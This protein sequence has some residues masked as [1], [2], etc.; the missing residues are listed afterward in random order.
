MNPRYAMASLSVAVILGG[1]VADVGPEKPIRMP[2][3]GPIEPKAPVPAVTAA[4]A[5]VQATA[6]AREENAAEL[7]RLLALLPWSERRDVARGVVETIG[8][9]DVAKAGWVVRAM[10]PGP[11]LRA[12]AEEVARLRVA[13]DPAAA[14]VWAL[15]EDTPAVEF[16]VRLAVAD[17]WVARDATGALRGITAQP[18]SPGR[19]EMVGFA[20]AAWG[21]RDAPAALAW[22][23]SLAADE[24]RTRVVTS[25]GFAWAQTEP[26]R[27][28]EILALL[29][30]ARDRW[31]IVGAI[32][33]TWVARAPDAAW[34]WARQL[35]AG[36]AREAA[37]AGI[38][39]GLGGARASRDASASVVGGRGRGT[40]GGGGGTVSPLPPGLEREDA[41]RREFD[42]V[43]R[44]SPAQAAD[45]LANH[46]APDRRDEMVDEVARRWLALNPEAARAWMERTILQ[47]DRREQLLREAGR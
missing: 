31:L 35:P 47:P 23:R 18:P 22:A 24:E 27:A 1:C 20:A 8:A 34:A 41:L 38:E 26:E 36:P 6:A 40:T 43:L 25:M 21:R 30:A 5:R 10:A 45:W 13:R 9:D 44:D 46:P 3:V 12:A 33:Q 11:A 28:V 14:M 39:T 16:A 15:A 17:A 32:A 29:P 19:N 2:I 7:R 42:D 37:L 4:E